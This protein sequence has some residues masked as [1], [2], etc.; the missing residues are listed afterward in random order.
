VKI[1]I[2]SGGFVGG[3]LKKAFK[4]KLTDDIKKADVIINTIGI[5]KEGK[6][7]FEESHV[8]TVKE[9]I[10]ECKNK[11]L[12]HISALGSAKNHP[13][14]YKH[15]K[16]VAEE[17]IKK[18]LSNYAIIKPSIILGEGQ[19]LYTDLEKFKNLP[20]IFVPKMKVQPV[21]I[22]NLT[23]FIKRIIKDD[24]KGEFEMCGEEVVSMK[25]LF[26]AVFERFG[27]KPLII[28]APKWFFKIILPFL[29]IAKIMSRDEY[30]M[31]EDNI[32][33]G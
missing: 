5:L 19:K 6:H 20:V 3:Y 10:K 15:T 8:K 18:E 30:L 4:Q 24:L 31:I 17:T 7:T 32:C 26:E 29:S 9:L 13:S 23:A 22:E 33:K 25:R 21:T 1:Y 14:R 11:K 12:I 28:E 16:A 2:T 27:K